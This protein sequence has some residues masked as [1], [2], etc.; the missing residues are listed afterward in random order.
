[1]NGLNVILIKLINSPNFQNLDLKQITLILY[2]FSKMSR[3]LSSLV[4]DSL[5]SLVKKIIENY[6]NWYKFLFEAKSIMFS[7]ATEGTYCER[8]KED[9]LKALDYVK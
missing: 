2:F 8:F 4:H 9:C 3:R 5:Y 6:P 7:V 1:M